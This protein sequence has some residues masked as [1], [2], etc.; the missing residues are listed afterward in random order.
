MPAARL[1]ARLDIKAPNLVK[2]VQLEGLR[3]LGDPHAFALHY[4]QQGVDELLYMDI[5]ASLYERN[6][7]L[8]LVERTTANVFVPL[9]VGGGLRSVA[10]VGKALRAGADKVAINTAAIKRPQLI[11]EVANA[12][13]RQ[14]MVLSIEAKRR[15]NGQWEAYFDNGREHTG[16]NAVD[17]AKK[18]CELGAG[19]ILLTS[20]DREGTAS[21]VDHELIQAIASQIPIPIIASGGV[22]QFSHIQQALDSGAQ[23]VAMAHVLH[24]KLCD[25]PT[26]R[27]QGSQAGIHLRSL[28]RL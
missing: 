22:G 12:Y 16:L 11:S 6:S 10:D 20:V 26:L 28:P 2:G 19:E 18:G 27:Q 23:A 21:G 3:K 8:D 24:Y 17:W 25:L 14:C 1:V 7:L 4:Y 5:V 9:T 13:G 15:P